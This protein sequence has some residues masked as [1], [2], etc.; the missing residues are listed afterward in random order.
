MTRD[1]KI[2]NTSIFLW[3]IGEGL[4]WFFQPLYL[5]EM[6]ANVLQ[7]GGILGITSLITMLTHIPAGAI[8]DRF[9]PKSMLATA[10][11]MG[12]VS[13]WLMFSAP[14]LL[15]FTIG[16]AMYGL[17]GFV[18]APLS[19][20]IT[21]ARG[22]VPFTRALTLNAAFFSTGMILGP[23]IGGLISAR[24]GLRSIYG[25]AAIIFSFSALLIFKLRRKGEVST[26]V[27]GSYRKLLNQRGFLITIGLGFIIVFALYLSLPLTPNFL[28]MER[29]ISLSE[30]GL[31]GSISSLGVVVLN[32]VAGRMKSGTG[33]FLTQILV[34]ISAAAIWLGSGAIW[35]GLGFFLAG[36][37][38]IAK[39]LIMGGIERIVDP[40]ELGVAFGVGE[41][42]GSL[43][44]VLAAPLAGYLYNLQPTLPFQTSILM[45]AI[46]VVATLVIFLP[47]QRSK[48]TSTLPN[49]D[50]QD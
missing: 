27:A 24:L 21:S 25:A 5:E 19:S 1:L 13:A 9:G 43:A 23:V 44:L 37:Y 8:S 50:G 3:G 22:T 6:G 14:S 40:S 31:L 39:S 36:G 16:A 15:I 32:L 30:L 33:L 46:T 26:R 49:A 17:S 35:M 10:W 48:S 4:F 38:R 41:T 12:A 42:L 11:I 20:F 28:Q 7:I 29:G 45:I 2:L 47:I 18:M 34:G